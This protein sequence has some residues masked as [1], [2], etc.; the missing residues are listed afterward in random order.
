LN[1]FRQDVS[2]RLPDVHKRLMLLAAISILDAAV[3]RWFLTSARFA[4][5]ALPQFAEVRAAIGEYPAQHTG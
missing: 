2:V 3:A 1:Q 4:A 5:D